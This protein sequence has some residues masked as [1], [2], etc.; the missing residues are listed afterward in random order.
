MTLRINTNVS[1][2]NA[3]R[4]LGA[5]DD[6]LNKSLE[7]L[8]SGLRINRGADDAAGLAVS[9][10]MR[11]QIKGLNQASRN[12]LDGI[13]LFNTAEGALN[14]VQSMLQRMRELSIQA[15]NG[16]LTSGDRTNINLEVQQ[17]KTQITSIGLQTRF[18]SMTVFT[19]NA[20]TLQVGAYNGH[21]MTGNIGLLQLSNFTGGNLLHAVVTTM[22][23]ASGLITSLD[24]AINHVSQ[25]RA[26]LGSLTNRL[27][28]TIANLDVTQENVSA[29]ESRIRD[30]DMAAEMTKLTRSQILSQ[31]ATAM[32]AQANQSPQGVLSL[33][34]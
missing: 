31:S 5:N 10:K 20:T 13:S 6:A 14:E 11:A 4:N 21:I 23:A 26:T 2:F 9:E 34:R 27:E 22:S 19:S 8:S 12:S 17:L 18:N 24:A 3:H 29:S 1:A 15:S 28:H 16:T 33:L 32:L 30:T 7:K 25:Q